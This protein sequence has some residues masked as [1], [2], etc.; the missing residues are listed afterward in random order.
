MFCILFDT[1]GI[2]VSCDIVRI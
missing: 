2:Y 1:S